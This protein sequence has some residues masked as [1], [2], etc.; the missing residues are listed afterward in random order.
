[1]TA[2]RI[3]PMR[4]DDWPRVATI[5]R[6]GMET[7]NATLEGRCPDWAAWDAAH[8]K[9]CRLVA[10]GEGGEAVAFAALSAVSA[11]AVYAGVAEVTL[12]VDPAAKGRGI[13]TAL[14]FALC[15]ESERE[16]FWTLQSSILQE[17][18][19]SLRVHAKCGFRQVGVRERI[20]RDARGVWRDTVLMERRSA[21]V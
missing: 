5:Y 1:M 14:L 21:A 4:P 18:A 10:E 13:G 8:L 9:A 16:G 6:L 15:R 19:A 12:Y 3:R 2:A 7:G 20:G 11:R 17:N